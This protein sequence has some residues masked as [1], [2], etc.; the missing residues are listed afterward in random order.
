MLTGVSSCQEL[1]NLR[2]TVTEEDG[3]SIENAEVKMY[4]LFYDAAQDKEITGKTAVDGSFEASHAA[5]L[6]MNVKINKKGYYKTEVDRLSKKQDHDLKIVLRKIKKPIPLHVKR[7]VLGFPVNNEWIGYDLEMGEW[8]APHG[9]GKISDMLLKCDTEKTGWAE[10]KGSLEIKFSESGGLILI[11]DKYLQMSQ[12][13]MPNIA[14]VDGYDPFFSR[15]EDSYHNKNC[16][17]GIGYFFRTR[18]KKMGDKIISSNYGKL[19][20]DIRFDPRESGW[21]VADKNKPKSF[22]AVSFTYYFNPTPND[23]NLEFDPSR[24]LFANPEP[25]EQVREP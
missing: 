7:V 23:R 16:R 6:R 19:A 21:H 12:M 17:N 11:E 2:V 9:L 22:A 25:T 8:V 15:K 14:P 20:T 10:G 4:F 18:V 24:N 13:K 1:R 3:T 5:T